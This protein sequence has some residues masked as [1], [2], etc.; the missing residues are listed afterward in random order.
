[1]AA[2]ASNAVNRNGHNYAKRPH[3]SGLM[4]L[5]FFYP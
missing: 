1:M 4:Q 3:I 5:V 2:W